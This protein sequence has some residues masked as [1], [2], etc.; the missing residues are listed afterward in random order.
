MAG[1]PPDV[2]FDWA[3]AERAREECLRAARRLEAAT[4]RRHGR[5]AAAQRKWRGPHRDRFDGLLADMTGDGADIAGE[6]RHVA[7]AIGDAADR[8]R[9]EQARRGRL[10]E[11]WRRA[12]Q[13]RREREAG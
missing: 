12:Q 8:A 4:Q 2:R 11:E 9:V 13:A 6:L 10:Q 5:A 7:A 3:V 1:P